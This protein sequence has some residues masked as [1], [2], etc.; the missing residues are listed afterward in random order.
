MK[1]LLAIST[2][3][4]SALALTPGQA[5]ALVIIDNFDT[6][7]VFKTGSNTTFTGSSTGAPGDIISGTRD[8]EFEIIGG[9]S[10]NRATLSIDDTTAIPPG[11]PDLSIS[12]PSNGTSITTLSYTLG[13]PYNLTPNGEDVFSLDILN[14]DRGATVEVTVNGTSFSVTTARGYTGQLTIPFSA[15]SPAP[16]FTAVNSI[17]LRISGPNDFDFRADNFN[18]RKVPEP[19]TILGTGFALAAL[20]G[21]KK[22][23]KN[24]KAQ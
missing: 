5:N 20:P 13:S 24:K 18:T 22:A 11:T 6:G 7:P 23:H 12:N 1:K 15:F 3:S 16:I 19:M 4:L 14:N 21:L 2:L 8:Y 9:S 17:Q 10:R